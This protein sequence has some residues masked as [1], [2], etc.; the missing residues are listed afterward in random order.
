MRFFRSRDRVDTRPPANSPLH[1]AHAHFRAGRYAEAAAEARAVA[2]LDARYAPAALSLVATALGAQ[3]R[4]AEAVAEYDALLP[5]FGRNHG[6]EHPFTLQLRSN[7]AQA[8]IALDRYAECEMECAAVARAADRGT[9]PEMTVL[10]VA[11]RNG[12]VYAVNAQGRHEEAEALARAAL[13]AR[14]SPDRLTLVL[15]LGLARSL[16]GQAR[17]DEAFAEALDAE[18]LYRSL[19]EDQ[20]RPETGTA[21]LAKATALV[22]LGRGAEAR[23]LVTAARDACVAAFGPDHYRVAEARALLDRVD[24]A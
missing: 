23:P 15:R 19:S 18:D 13:A 9:G 1:L 21:E 3:G 5:V 20:R 8:L 24:G 12:Q 11:A 6:A 10:A 2:A 22:G 7:R 16:N 17:H 14:D 4:H